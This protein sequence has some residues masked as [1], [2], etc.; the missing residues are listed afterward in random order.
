[1]SFDFTSDF[2]FEFFFLQ[3]REARVKFVNVILN[4]ALD[5]EQEEENGRKRVTN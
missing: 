3:S 4:E 5:D 2:H 1:M